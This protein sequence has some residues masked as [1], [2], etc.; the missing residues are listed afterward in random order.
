MIPASEVSLETFAR[1]G[2]TV[3]NPIPNPRPSATLIVESGMTIALVRDV[4]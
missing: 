3:K 2:L 4:P 1:V